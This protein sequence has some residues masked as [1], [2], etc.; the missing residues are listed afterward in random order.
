MQKPVLLQAVNISKGFGEGKNRVTVLDGVSLSLGE[1]EAVGL[2][3]E[4]GSG[5]STLAKILCGLME[6][7]S[8]EVFFEGKEISKQKTEEFQRLRLGLQYIF[9]S[10]YASLS[11]YKTVYQ[12]VGEAPV[13][14]RICLKKEQRE[15]VLS[16]LEDCGLTQDFLTR[17]PRQLSGGQCQKVAVARALA[18]QPRLLVCDEITSSL[19]KESAQELIELIKSI[20]S[21]HKM[22]VFFIT[23]QPAYLLG[24]AGKIQTMHEGKIKE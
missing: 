1:G 24:F 22:A 13:Y 20:H 21:H 2:I 3:G 12:L 17:Y 7:D 11:P 19:D 8:G 23:H 14:H 6:K 16:V 15:Y 10:P 4:N 9:Q 5:K 18:V